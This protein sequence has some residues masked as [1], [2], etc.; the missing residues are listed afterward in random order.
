MEGEDSDVG[1][2]R[3]EAFSDGVLAVIITVTALSL[4][5]PV[6]GAFAAMG[7]RLPELLVYGA[8]FVFLGIYWNNHHHLLRAATRISS[9]VMWSNLALLFFLSLIPVMTEWV[10]RDY[11]DTAPAATYGVV[12]LASALAFSALTRSI[13][14]A[15]ARPV[16][17]RIVGRDRKGLVS[18][19]LYASGTALAFVSPWISYALYVAVSVM[20]FVPDRRFARAL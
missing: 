11:R 7:H 17:A 12:A 9:G 6:S 20:W 3:L 14:H 16:V 1:T 15:E 18:Q 13:V 10:A 2:S 8:N 19:L 5:A 4:H